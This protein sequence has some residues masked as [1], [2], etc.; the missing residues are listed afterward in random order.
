MHPAGHRAAI[1]Q[2]HDGVVRAQQA[3]AVGLLGAGDVALP[4]APGQR[5]PV[6]QREAGAG[7]PGLDEAL[8]AAVQGR[9]QH[10]AP[11]VADLMDQRAVGA[12]RPHRFQERE[13]ESILDQALRIARRERQIGD[14][15]IARRFGIGQRVRSAGQQFIDARRAEVAPAKSR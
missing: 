4:A 6:L 12:V 7:L 3:A 2:A 5:E 14:L 10:L 1:G 15:A 13:V 9:H 11:P 8:G